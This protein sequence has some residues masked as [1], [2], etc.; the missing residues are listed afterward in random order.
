MSTKGEEKERNDTY[1]TVSDYTGIVANPEYISAILHTA[2]VKYSFIQ[3]AKVYYPPKIDPR[4][5]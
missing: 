4:Y 5:Y 2:I 1:F 3:L